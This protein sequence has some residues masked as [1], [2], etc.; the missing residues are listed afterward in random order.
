MKSRLDRQQAEVKM[1][2]AWLTMPLL[3]ILTASSLAADSSGEDRTAWFAAAKYGVF[4]HYLNGLQNNPDH[5]A[6]LGKETSWDE[7]VAEFDVDLFAK[8]MAEAGAGYV[9]FTVM[10]QQ[11]FMIAPNATFDKITGYRPG[12]AC[13]TRDL[14]EDLFH[15]LAKYNIPL[16]LYWTG[17]GP[18]ADPQAAQAFGWDEPVP[19]AFVRRWAAVAAEY[20]R[21]YGPK[22]KGWWVDGCYRWLGY[23]DQKLAI[24]AEGLRAGY[25][26]RIIAFN[27]GVEEK[28]RAYSQHEDFT[29]GEQND[30]FDRPLSRF[31]NGKQWHILAP[32]GNHWAEPGTRLGKRELAD[33]VHTVTAVG[34][35]VSIDVL[36]Y[37]DGDLDRSQLEVLKSLRQGLAQ[38]AEW[39]K[40]WRQGKAVPPNNKAWLKPARLLNIEGQYPLV[41]SGYVFRA[42]FGVDGS[43]ETFAQAGFEWPWTYEVDLLQSELIRRIVIQ[44]GPGYATEYEVQLS[45]DAENWVTVAK[46][47]QGKGGQVELRLEP[48]HARFIRIRG[49]KPDGPN[50][51]GSQMSIAELQVFE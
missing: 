25:P 48:R 29:A 40:A 38:R 13:A 8:R 51:E 18:I 39:A 2:Q 41:P 5:V 12:E 1:R 24:L 37:R 45:E 44:F 34:G 30:F 22:V 27:P 10:Q 46:S 7:C 36:L 11:R 28:V 20:G 43:P 47:T 3:V 19:E 42:E 6:S 32:L 49:L 31:V 9:V 21:R 33:Y 26:E 14:I 4:V 16:L 35:V 23:N 17:D 50:Q 15:A